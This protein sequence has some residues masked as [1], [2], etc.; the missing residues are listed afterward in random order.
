MIAF[1]HGTLEAK[2][3]GHVVINVGGIGF[4]ILVPASTLAS[5]GDTGRQVRLHTHL[6]F[7]E[8]V[9]ALYGF[10]TE[11]ELR[12]FRALMSVGGIGPRIAISA[13]S[14]MTPAQLVSAIIAEDQTALSRVPGVGKKTAARIILELKA[15]L[16]KEWIIAPEAGGT[17]AIGADAVA[18]LV[19]LGYGQAEAR[20]ALAAVKDASGLPLEEQIRQALQRIGSR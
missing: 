19:A 13:L 12:M 9:Q 4:H 16:E 2:A 14:V 15:T 18:A 7:K 20:T 17:V 1:I 3:S 8:D 6:H 11:D 5:L 10:A